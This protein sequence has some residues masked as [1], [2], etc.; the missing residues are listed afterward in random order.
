MRN[1]Y[2]R[3]GCVAGW[4]RDNSFCSVS[5]TA[6][7]IGRKWHPVIVH[8]LLD[9]G[10]LGFNDLERD[11]EPISSTVLS[12]S[13][14]DLEAKDIIERR[15]VSEKPFRVEYGLTAQ[16]QSLEPVIEAMGKWGASYLAA[17]E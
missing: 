5:C 16:G 10:P 17:S 9:I 14:E 7:L 2:E 6:R 3:E 1:G 4:C 13:L 11:L 12:E 8:R 15:V